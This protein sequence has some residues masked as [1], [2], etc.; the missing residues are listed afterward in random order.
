MI[1][2]KALTN[3]AM[4][5]LNYTSKRVALW[6]DV[7]Y[8][9]CEK[10]CKV[11]NVYGPTLVCV[12]N[13]PTFPLFE[14]TRGDEDCTNWCS[15]RIP[16]WCSCP[17]SCWTPRTPE[18]YRG[19]K[20]NKLNLNQLNYTR[21]LSHLQ[22]SAEKHPWISFLYDLKCWCLNEKYHHLTGKWDSSTIVSVF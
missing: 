9:T 5:G 11:H 13:C 20:T 12:N 1:Y 6:Y 7:F 18:K 2:K 4:F 10:Q 8:E 22:S 14:I 15:H 19:K 21:Q 17:Q 16:A 3:Q